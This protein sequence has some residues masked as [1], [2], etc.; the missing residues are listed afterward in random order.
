[1]KALIL[2]VLFLLPVL[3]GC[4]SKDNKTEP[5][6]PSQFETTEQRYEVKGCEELKKEVEEFNKAHPE[7]EPF[8][9]DC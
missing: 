5:P 4:N 9:A 6:L 2:F 1:M 8:V 7:R 3:V